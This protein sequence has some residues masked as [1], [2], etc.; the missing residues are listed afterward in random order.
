MKKLLFSLLLIYPILTKAQDGFKIEKVDSVN[1]SKDEIYSATKMFI[2][3][4]WKSAQ[5]VIQNDDKDGGMILVKGITIVAIPTALVN[6][7]EYT[8]HYTVKFLIKDKKFKVIVS[9]INCTSALCNEVNKWPI[10]N[11]CENCEFPGYFKT[12]LKEEKWKLLMTNVKANIYNISIS[13][14]DYVKKKGND[15]NNF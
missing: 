11:Y 9:D 14:V 7:T 5:N 10:I 8:Y 4:Y 15:D 13:Y 1:K 2:A 6:T 3:E 12:S